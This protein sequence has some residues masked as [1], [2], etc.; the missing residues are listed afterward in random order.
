M[1]EENVVIEVGPW[2]DR[3]YVVEIQENGW[4]WETES[5]WIKKSSA[6]YRA[7]E[8]ANGHGQPRVRVRKEA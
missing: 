3:P 6:I 1:N 5:R 2:Q 4:R 8:L 7:E